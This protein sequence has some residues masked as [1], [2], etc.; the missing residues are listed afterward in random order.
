MVDQAKHD[1]I[2]NLKQLISFFN[3][4]PD[5]LK[6]GNERGSKLFKMKSEVNKLQT[7]HNFS[8]DVNPFDKVV[9][10]SKMKQITDA[11][12]FLERQKTQFEY[13][14]KTASQAKPAPEDFDAKVHTDVAWLET[15]T[16]A[17]DEAQKYIDLI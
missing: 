3:S 11:R 4:L 16:S 10:S 13:I 1:F 9:L 2:C 15:A 8:F 7:G 5:A 12:E 6:Q 17:L 14:K